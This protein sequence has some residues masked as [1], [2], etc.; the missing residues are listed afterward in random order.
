MTHSRLRIFAVTAAISAHLAGCSAAGGGQFDSRDPV[1][2]G[3]DP[4]L[5]EEVLASP[6][7]QWRVEG[8]NEELAASRYQGMVRNF[9]LC[10]SAFAAYQEWLTSG[11]APDLPAQP[12]PTNP[13]LYA[14]DLDSSIEIYRDLLSSGDISLLRDELTKETG[15]GSWVPA[16]PQDSDG[17][18]IATAIRGGATAGTPTTG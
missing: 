3:L 7:A 12:V 13:G 11:S 8:D 6:A 9:A 4:M 10:R 15:C 14:S 17:P 2:A 16:S 18:T 1:F 5:V